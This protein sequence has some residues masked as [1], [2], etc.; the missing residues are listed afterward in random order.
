MKTNDDYWKFAESERHFNETQAGIR[1]HAATWMLAAF[2]AIAILLKTEDKVNW[3]V[4]PAVLVGVVSIMATLGLLVLWI[5]DQL[6]YQ[7]LLD[8][9][10]IIALK[11][12]YDDPQLP[13]IRAMMMYSAEGKGMARWM[14]YFYTLPMWGFLAVSMAAT[15]LRRSIGSTSQGVDT[16]QSLFVLIAI[17]VAQFGATLWVQWKKSEVGAATRAALFGDRD[18]AAMFDGT[19]EA[20]ARFAT[21]IARHRAAASTEGGADK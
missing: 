6:V 1:N 5:N 13:P 19:D 16:D 8:S 11:M 12:E 20:R 4:S 17:C 15:L 10:F 21:V 18:F 14:T 7:R 9:G 2:A 3:L